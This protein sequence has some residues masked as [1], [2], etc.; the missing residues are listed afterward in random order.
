M[1]IQPFKLERYFAKYEF[2]TKYLLSCSDCEPISMGELLQMADSESK[3]LWEALGLG[4]TESAGHP[5]LREAITE[6]YE[7]IAPDDILTVVPE[8]GIFL[9]MNALLE[10]GDH[11]VC[12]FPGYQSLYEVAGSI[13]CEVTAWE[14]NEEDGWHFDLAQLEKKIKPNTRLVVANFPHNPTGF[15]TSGKIFE[16]LVRL[17]RQKGIYL[18]SDEM[19]RFLEIE[20]GG[21]LPSACEIYENAVSLFGLSKTFGLPGLRTGWIVSKNREILARMAALKDYTTICASAPGEILAIIALKNRE[22]IIDRQLARV[23]RNIAVLDSFFSDHAEWFTWNRPSGGSI[24]F[25]RLL[26]SKGADAFCEDLIREE[27]IMLVPSSAFNFGN[28]HV[29]VGFGRENLPE[30]IERLSAYLKNRV[31]H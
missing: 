8:E 26:A 6:I 5:L 30:V 29:R 17:L 16:N 1:K 28:R 22:R 31:G 27:G 20:A 25:P 15:V 14:P 19:Y 7:G 21:T 24:C 4:Y 10:P 18:L 9:F 2:S 3:R 23:R 13:G 12:T 11:V